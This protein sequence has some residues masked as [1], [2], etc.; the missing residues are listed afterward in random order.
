M[1]QM[2][3][4]AA[5]LCVDMMVTDAVRQLPFLPGR[6]LAPFKRSGA[7]F[8]LRLRL[9]FIKRRRFH[10][11]LSGKG[12]GVLLAVRELNNNKLQQD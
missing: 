11:V 6:A 1:Q 3:G 9:V 7:G 10:R 5:F 12:A 8:R 2:E 4:S